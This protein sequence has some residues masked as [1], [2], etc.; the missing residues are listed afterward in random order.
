MRLRGCRSL[1]AEGSGVEEEERLAGQDSGGSGKREEEESSR[2]VV[3]CFQAEHAARSTQQ[4]ARRQNQ[5]AGAAP[6]SGEW[7]AA[8]NASCP[9]SHGAGGA[10]AEKRPLLSRAGRAR[11]NHS[12]DCDSCSC[13]RQ[14]QGES[15]E[16]V[17]GRGAV[18][19]GEE[20]RSVALAQV[21]WASDRAWEKKARI[22]G[23]GTPGSLRA[24]CWILGSG[25]LVLDSTG[26][27]CRRRDDDGGSTTL[28]TGSTGSRGC[29]RD[30]MAPSHTFQQ[31]MAGLASLPAV[32]DGS[33]GLLLL[34]GGDGGSG[35]CSKDPARD[36]RQGTEGRDGA[37]LV[38]AVPA[39]I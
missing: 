32:C 16:P 8:E 7:A 36:G 34:G 6:V 29:C 23:P 18:L 26:G 22:S 15:G 25:R 17:G 12:T 4:H 1:A 10:P 11:W 30:A 3:Q 19:W 27:W 21:T 9:S 35:T 37:V 5:A 31:Q 39:S 33:R 20:P 13:Q 2:R 38:F 14:R 28:D 24:D